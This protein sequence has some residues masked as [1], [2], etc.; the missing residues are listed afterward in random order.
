[1]NDMKPIK[2]VSVAA[3]VLVVLAG[4]TLVSF[5]P[6]PG[7]YSYE[8]YL[9]NQL[10]IKEHLY[11]RTEVSSLP[12][13]I[14][15]AQGELSIMFNNCNKVDTSRKISIKDDNDKTLK[16]WTFADSPDIKNRMKIKASEIS[17]FS[18]KHSSV[19]L[20]YSSI[21]VRDG[22]HLVNL[23]LTGASAATR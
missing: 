18:N 12:L 22:V 5:A 9:N 19:K 8:V 4:I 11:G 10:I 16:E 17:A 23:E 21:E 3:T 15:T 14:T 20:V 2:L 6:V 13:N 1:M 7:G